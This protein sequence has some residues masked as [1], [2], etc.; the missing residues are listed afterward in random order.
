M[1]RDTEMTITGLVEA[2]DTIDT[3]VPDYQSTQCLA[4]RVLSSFQTTSNVAA[5][6][7]LAKSSGTSG[8]A[9][10]QLHHVQQTRLPLYHS[11]GFS[12]IRLSPAEP[13]SIN[14]ETAV[15]T[16]KGRQCLARC[17]LPE[18]PSTRRAY[19]IES[20]STLCCFGVARTSRVRASQTHGVATL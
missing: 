18:G 20:S 10:E 9:V 14:D 7:S 19:S 13:Q 12:A 4:T 15:S 2:A 16:G 17:K 3:F 1:S 8:S 6:H 11:A 5:V